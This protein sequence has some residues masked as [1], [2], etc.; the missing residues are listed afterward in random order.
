M[1]L[2]KSYTG[3]VLWM[4]LFIAGMFVMAFIPTD[5]E[6]LITRLIMNWMTLG[7]AGMALLIRLK[8]AVYWYNGTSFEDAVKAGEERRKRFAQRH[9]ERFAYLAGIYL[10]Y[11]LLAQLY[12]L[13][14]WIDI[15]L[16]TVGLIGVAIST[17]R[18]KL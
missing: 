17:L 14:F 2:R 12:G 4:I 5:N 11:S 6:A 1:P 15:V 7:I 16:A 3:F 13:P 8:Q 18:I 9:F 10:I